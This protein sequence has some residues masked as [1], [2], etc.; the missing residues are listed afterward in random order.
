MGMTNPL[1]DA[2]E[3]NVEASVPPYAYD[4]Y[5]RVV[6]G[7]MR[8]ALRGGERSIVASLERSDDPIQ[9]AALGSIKLAERISERLGDPTLLSIVGPAATTLMLQA[10]D[11]A[12]IARIIEVGPIEL[13]RAVRILSSQTGF[14]S[15]S[16]PAERRH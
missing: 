2:A 1:L 13:G 12:G 5:L 6:V 16:P 15:P 3:Q 10:L 11:F 4:G 8:A 9:D 14:H 7:G